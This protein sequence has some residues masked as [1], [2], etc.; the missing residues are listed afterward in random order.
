MSFETRRG[1][2]L[3]VGWLITLG[4]LTLMGMGLLLRSR[5]PPVPFPPP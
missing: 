3:P 5:R 1:R 4:I 2:S